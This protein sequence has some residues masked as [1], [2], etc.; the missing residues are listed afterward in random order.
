MCPLLRHHLNDSSCLQ[1]LWYQ[2]GLADPSP[3][4]AVLWH[5]LMLLHLLAQLLER[6]LAAQQQCLAWLSPEAASELTFA[7]ELCELLSE[8]ELSP[9]TELA[10]L[11]PELEMG[12][13]LSVAELSPEAELGELA[14]ASSEH[15]G[16]ELVPDCAAHCLQLV[17]VKV[18]SSAD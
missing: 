8:A 18:K 12:E 1:Q 4:R 17:P 2:P 9:A 11:S 15:Q 13:L 6:H 3:G 7:A 16:W 5:C 14:G 10:G